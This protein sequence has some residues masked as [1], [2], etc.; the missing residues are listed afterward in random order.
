MSDKWEYKT[1]LNRP[2]S[3]DEVLNNYGKQGWEVLSSGMSPDGQ[4]L[5]IL[6]KRKMPAKIDKDYNGDQGTGCPE[7][8]GGF[9]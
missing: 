1:I 5:R 9:S 8:A 4:N 2:S 3:L 7:S 6:L